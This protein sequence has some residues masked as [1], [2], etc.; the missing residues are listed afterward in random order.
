MRRGVDVI[1]LSNPFHEKRIVE[2]GLRFWGAGEYF[3]IFQEIG[4]NPDYL[5][6]RKGPRKVWE[7]VLKTMPELYG[8]M[9]GLIKEESPDLVACHILEYGGMLAAI[10]GE[11]PYATISPTPMGWFSTK[12][13]GYL[14]Y[15][16][17]PLWVRSIQGKCLRILMNAAFKYTLRRKCMKL[18]LPQEFGS[19][20]DV[21]GKA[22]A[23][24]GLWS[25]T[26]RAG[27]VDDPPN[28]R[29]CGFVRDEH[30]KDWQDVPEDIALLFEG[31]K[32]PVVVGLGSTASLHGDNIYRCAA[33]ACKRIGWP[34][35]LIG[36]GMDKFSDAGKNIFAV[37]FAPFGWVFPRAG[38]IIHHGGVNTTA[39][40][41]RSPVPSLVVPHAYDQFDNAIRV[42]HMGAARRIK[43][44]KITA[45]SF[46]TI[47]ENILAQNRMQQQ[48]KAI[49]QRIITEP[50]GA[51]VAVEALM[52]FLRKKNS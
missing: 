39:E 3:D 35:L 20:E 42:E 50:D 26:L 34:C 1:F 28:S 10:E 22:S 14:S 15:T 36:K 9:K 18:G 32:R 41:L 2:A 23:N 40:A 19:I 38:V 12:P 5:H 25:E 47:L 24:L 13:C 44:N 51:D 43:V 8:A 46:G 4:D 7:L 33:E 6:A 21:F 17:Y 49:S 11:V 45:Q 37:D 16:E 31:E 48:A 30:V 52:Q 27:A 29:I